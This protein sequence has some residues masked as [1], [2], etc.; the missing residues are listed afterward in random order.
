MRTVS[1]GQR[2][3]ATA[4]SAAFLPL[5][6]SLSMPLPLTQPY[7]C[8]SFRSTL[9]SPWRSHDEPDWPPKLTP[10]RSVATASLPR[11]LQGPPGLMEKHLANGS[12][13]QKRFR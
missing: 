11:S 7:S 6:M 9:H 4:T 1:G 5:S 13:W 2:K 10:S 3:P 12:T 8:S